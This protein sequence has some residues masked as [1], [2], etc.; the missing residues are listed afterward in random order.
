[1]PFAALAPLIGMGISGLAGLFGG[2][3]QN[4]TQQTGTQNQQFQTSNQ[5]GTSYNLNPFQQQLAGMFTQG[6]QDL[7]KNATNLLLTL[8]RVCSRLRGRERLTIK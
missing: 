4:Q 7:Y 2:G 1:M 5:Q 3:K 6:A 8:S